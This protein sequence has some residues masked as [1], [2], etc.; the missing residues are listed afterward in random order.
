[1]SC[2]STRPTTRVKLRHSLSRCSVTHFGSPLGAMRTCLC[3]DVLILRLAILTNVFT[4]E[5]LKPSLISREI[6]GRSL[7]RPFGAVNECIS[8]ERFP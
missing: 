3:G 4:G 1:M 6:G 7:E 8:I 2:Q 5:V